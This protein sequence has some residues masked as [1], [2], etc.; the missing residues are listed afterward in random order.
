MNSTFTAKTI[1]K[2]TGEKHNGQIDSEF[3]NDGCFRTLFGD[4]CVSIYV[5]GD[6]ITPEIYNF[7]NDDVYS[8]EFDTRSESYTN[9]RVFEY[10]ESIIE[11]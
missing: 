9:M 7:G 10:I 1:I 2:L 5:N 4:Y 6:I 8:C 3:E 11:G